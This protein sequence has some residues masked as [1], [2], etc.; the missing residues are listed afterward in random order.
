[1]TER[2][3][4]YLGLFLILCFV[5]LFFQLNNI[6]VR[7]ASQFA[8][9]PNNP[10]NYLAQ[11]NEP[12]G[13]ILTSGGTIIAESK[14]TSGAYPYL[15]VYPEGP[16][17]ADVTGFDSIIYGVS[18]A[19]SS[20]DSALTAHTQSSSNI[21]SLFT[22][23]SVADN[24][25]LTV[26]NGLQEVAAAA[27]G[28]HK[29]AV[30][31]LDPRTGAVLALYSSPTYDPNLLASHNIAEEHKA[32]STY[33]SETVNPMLARAYRQSYPPGST[34]KMVTASAVFDY[35]PAIATHYYPY[36]SDVALP[37][38]TRLLHNYDNEL[39]GGTILILFEVSCDTGFGQIGIALGASTLYEQAMRYG[40]NT[41]PPFDLAAVASTF[42]PPSSFA[43]RVPELAYSAIGQEDVSA[44]PL[45]MALVAGGV[46]NGGVIM[47]PHVLKEIRGPNGQ[48]VS[49]YHPKPWRTA[50][51]PS[52]AASV[53]RLM[54]AVVEGSQGTAYGLFPP[55][56]DA[57]AKTGTAQNAPGHC[58]T[59]WLAAFA[60]ASNPQVVVVAVVPYQ[61]G[62]PANPT[63]NAV[64]GPVVR[65]V[66]AAALS[67]D[68][69]SGS[70]GT[71]HG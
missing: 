28:N 9:S 47:T 23:G 59:N 36:A 49:S 60:P 61:P 26:S 30:V 20:F 35:K 71:P 40:F 3:I 38:T 34:F 70:G 53:K 41:V 64:A 62:L 24:V 1:M 57:A 4:R 12:R 25:V 46:A 19:E 65:K 44:T 21:G 43:G 66:L 39:C 69:G 2:R 37:D 68:R 55:S 58:C 27:L 51:S 8:N 32:W 16:L 22:S 10:K 52:T 13:D 31:A 5:A 48:L 17:F 54:M 63:G 29:G 56:L 67:L 14:P 6:Q 7:Q 11:T 45:Q 18:G 33:Q 15:R 50:A 42:P